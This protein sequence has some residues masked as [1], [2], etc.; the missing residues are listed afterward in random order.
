MVPLAWHVYSGNFDIV[1][2]LLDN[3]AHI[4][5]DFDLDESGRKGTVLDVSTMLTNS[6]EGQD[7]KDDPILRVHELLI[8]RGGKKY[9]DLPAEL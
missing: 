3:G 2:L 7:G 8:K 9:K 1:Q 5:L 4:N 6:R